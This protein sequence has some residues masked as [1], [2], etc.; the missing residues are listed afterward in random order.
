[1]PVY[2][3]LLAHDEFPSSTTHWPA[4]PG[5][6]CDGWA[7]WFDTT[8]LLFSVL[9]G[10]AQ[11][12]PQQVACSAYENKDAL[13]ALAAPMKQVKA[14]WQW[15]KACMEPLPSHWSA[16][17]RA[18]WQA[19]DTTITTSQRQWLLLDSAMLC[20]HDFDEP[21]FTHFLHAQRDVC[22]QWDGHTPVLPDVL[23]ILQQTPKSQLGWWS[24]SVIARTA[25]IE[26]DDEQDWP[27]WLAEHYTLRHFGAWDEET[28]TYCVVPKRHPSTGLPPQNE[29][30]RMSLPVGMVTPYGRWLQHPDDGAHLV[31]PSH[32]Y[33][34]V[35][36][37]ESV[38]GAGAVSGLKDF[39]G[40]WVLPSTA[41]YLNAT[42]LTPHVMQ[43]QSPQ[44]PDAC[45]LYSLP[46]M[47]LLY[48]AITE[49]RYDPDTDAFVR[50]CRTETDGSNTM[51]VLTPQ[52]H[53]LF[54]STY[55]H[56]GDFNLKTGLAIA[57]RRVAYTDSKGQPGTR[58][59][60]G[61]VHRSGKEIVA[62]TYDA[63]ERGFS[64]SPP[65]VLP[66]SKLLAFT[67]QGQPHVYSTKGKLLAS[68]NIWC[69][70]LHRK[71]QKNEL[72]AFRGEKP[73]AELGMFSIK[74]FSFTPTGQTWQDYDD[75]LQGVIQRLK[76]APVATATEIITRAALIK[77]EDTDWMQRIAAI[78]C[79]GQT[80][81]A[82]Q[83]LHD[84]RSCV[85]H[86]E[87]EALG[88]ESEDEDG[89]TQDQ[90]HIELPEGDNFYTLYW[91]HLQA[92]ATQ[93]A[94]IDWKDT[95]ALRSSTWL[96]GAYDWH[97]DQDLQGDAINDGFASLARHLAPQGLALLHLPTNDDAWRYAV[98]RSQDAPQLVA[99]L[100]QAARHAWVETT[101]EPLTEG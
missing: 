10:D 8:P 93:F 21:E 12:L 20:P 87:A 40:L 32:G 65:K 69:S 38:P 3:L 25:A 77:A 101:S 26:Q 15:L 4:E 7:E 61:V 55:A 68:P 37:P 72:M 19:I 95:D 98:V 44:T 66:G 23:Q 70:H 80:A 89:A 99:M 42:A 39:N 13:S 50:I 1:M 16:S 33:I 94:H 57:Y 81:P 43:C 74:D 92:I 34:S 52:G 29:D 45:D 59:C 88:W 79:L 17:M 30:E 86:P 22:R 46:G 53:P 24:D 76:Q 62:C 73:T 9:M 2:A 49:P 41:G 36:Q 63:I 90:Q 28:E 64:D 82:T 5:G 47:D 85:A 58:F 6:I 18:Q 51:Q 14:R 96:P 54:D 97:W 83:L 27:A 60:E 35:W 84:W 11:Q 31:F 67:H 56:M 78:V 48:S 91:L 71:L 100:G 75:A